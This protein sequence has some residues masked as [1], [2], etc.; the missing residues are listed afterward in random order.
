MPADKVEE[1]DAILRDVLSGNTVTGLHRRRLRKDGS[2]ITVSISTAPFHDEQGQVRGTVIIAEDITKQ[3][4]T[5]VERNLLLVR[6]REARSRAEDA[7]ERISRLQRISAALSEA[8]TPMEVADVILTQGTAALGASAAS[9]GRSVPE[10]HELEIVAATGYPD[11]VLREFARFPVDAP[12]PLATAVRTGRAIWIESPDQWKDQF[13]ALEPARMGLQMTASASIPLL[14]KGSAL[15]AL[16][17]SFAEARTFSD[18]DK[19]FALSLAQQCAQAL[20]RSRLYEAEHLAR[21]EAE[22]ARHRFEFLAQASITLSSSLDYSTTLA[23]VARLAVPHIADWCSV[24]IVD[25]SG[26]ARLLAV[27][28]VDPEKVALAHEL[29]ARYPLEP[30]APT[31][32]PHVLRTSQP[33]LIPYIPD[34]ML[35]ELTPDPELLRTLRA[36]GLV[37]AMTVPLVARGRVLGAIT[38]FS[39]ES[40]HRYGGADLALASD[41]ASR[42][43]VAV[44][45][46]RLLRE[47]RQ[48]ALEREAILGQIADGIVMADASGTIVFANTVA[49]RLFGTQVLGIPPSELA[50]AFHAFRPSG[51]PFRSEDLPLVRATLRNET[52]VNED[53]VIRHQDGSDRIIACSATP[54]VGEDGVKLGGV[55]S[56][57]DVTTQRTLERQKDDFLSAAAHDLKTPLTTIKGLAQILGRRAARANTPETNSLLDGLHRID[58]TT[59]RMSGLINELLDISRIEMGRSLDLMRAETDLVALI[60]QIASEQQHTTD[61]HDVRVYALAPDITGGWDEVRLE[62]AFTNLV[63]NAITYSPRGGRVEVTVDLER[64]EPARAVVRIDDEGLGIP[65]QDLPTIFERFHRG[66]NVSGRIPGTGIGLAG[67]REIFQQH[68]GQITVR[69][70]AGGGT[71]FE[72]T[73]PLEPPPVAEESERVD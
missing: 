72:V 53:V 25:E 4:R 30:E 59:S 54:V 20:E 44:D 60:R 56:F 39:A 1:S 12:F 45:N 40:E 10:G 73:L 48:G 58:A 67:A 24:Y 68:G 33:E 3:E 26:E 32:V 22:A 8:L 49:Q 36:L 55:V 27:A 51:E 23:S 62:R 15:G 64:S 66:S 57:R 28:H 42:A 69:R 38:F 47:T 35:V 71:S 19:S 2:Y 6:E 21:G 37:S 29:N 46:A 41:L 65:E 18:E 5:E 13:P 7:A 50:A 61:L 17:L 34:E 63:S 9:I 11:C 31:G 14:V 70:R 52:I 16:G 43:A